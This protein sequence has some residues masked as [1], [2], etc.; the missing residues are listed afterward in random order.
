M[1]RL[2]AHLPGRRG[3]PAAVQECLDAGD[4]ADER[5]LADAR[6]LHK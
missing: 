5:Q 3:A 6:H 4:V 1:P 2:H